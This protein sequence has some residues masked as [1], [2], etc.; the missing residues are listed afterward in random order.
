MLSSGAPE[1]DA[2]GPRPQERKQAEDPILAGMVR[3]D[4]IQTL[5]MQRTR[6][7]TRIDPSAR[8]SKLYYGWIVVGALALAITGGYGILNYAFTVFIKPMSAELGWTIGQLTGAYSLSGLVSVLFAPILGRLLDRHGSRVI[9]SVGTI[10]AA[11][12]LLAW[13]SVTQL[14]MFYVIVFLLT[15]VSITVLYPPAF[16]TVSN[17]FSRKRRSALTLLTFTG[18]F[19]AIIFTPL[20]QALVTSYGWRATLVIYAGF[21]LAIN[22]PLLALLLRR[23]PADLGLSVDGSTWPDGSIVEIIEANASTDVTLAAAVRHDGFWWL[24]TAF[25]LNSIVMTFMIIHFVPFLIERDYSAAFA[26][27]MYGLIGVASLPGRLIFTP[28]GDKV[29]AGWISVFIFLAQTASFLV[30][31]AGRGDGAVIAFLVL[32]AAGYGAISPTNAALIADLFGVRYFGTISGTIS[33]VSDASTAVVLA[34]LAILRDRWGSYAGLIWVLVVLSALSVVCMIA[35]WVRR[36]IPSH[37]E[38]GIAY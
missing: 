2:T 15:G 6:N 18:G 1:Q 33:M 11:L 14:P 17:W 35:A 32:F 19:A 20:T 8:E 29:P 5:R 24:T 26:A 28:L 13:S 37:I 27:T 36:E 4:L 30:L 22:L 9:M 16:W 34:L 25:T 31:A 10:A 3:T 23:R 21:L 7:V 38:Q 12:L